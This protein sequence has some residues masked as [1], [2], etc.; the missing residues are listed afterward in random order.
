MYGLDE[1][2]NKLADYKTV[3]EI[4][5]KNGYNVPYTDESSHVKETHEKMYEKYVDAKN[6]LDG[7]YVGS[8]QEAYNQ[9]QE[10]IDAAAKVRDEYDKS[11]K[12][13][14]K[15]IDKEYWVYS[16]NGK[17]YSFANEDLRDLSRL[18]YDG[19]Y[20][21]TNMFLTS[22]D[23]QVSAINEQLKLLQSAQ[24][25]LYIASHPQYTYTTTLDNFISLYDY[26]NYTDNLNLGDYVYLGVRD[27]YAVKLRI[28][29][30]EYNPLVMDGDIT[31]EFSNMVQSK[32]SRTDWSYL[33]DQASSSGKNSSQGSSNNFL[34]NEGITLTAGLIQKLLSSGA[35]SNKV[36]QIVNNEFAG[37]IAGGSGSISINEL[38]AKMIKVT[39]IIGENG[40]FEYLQAKLISADKIVADSGDF[41]KLYAT[42]GAIDNLLAGN[43]SSEISHVIKLTADNVTIDEA[44]IRDMIAVNI[45][46]SMLKAGDISTDKFHI[47]SDDGG[48]D[49]AGNTMQFK[50]ENNVVRIQIGRDA[51]G[52]FTFCLYDETGNGI[53]IDSAGVKES[54][55]SD[56]LIKNNMIADKSIEKNKLAFN[57]VE[58]DENG[59]IDSKKVL[60]DGK[61]IDVEFTTIKNSVTTLDQK[62]DNS[63]LYNIIISTSQGSVLTPKIPET[64][65]YAHVIKL[66]QDVTDE[67]D[68]SCF[69]WKRVSTDTSGDTYWNEQHAT[70]AKSITVRKDDIL[71]GASFG[72]YFDT[73]TND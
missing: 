25:D 27:D 15:E 5:E 40:F 7:S 72:C 62:I 35:F 12:S 22:S 43:V 54:A 17:E 21:N 31:I 4:C 50:D 69:I 52:Q 14:A 59:N 71:Y 8:C 56:G 9:R 65:L 13:A 60:V 2:K 26:K 47:L 24:D 42:V 49:I 10:E 55:I 64:I 51:K 16:Q 11:R 53:L 67:F 30:I 39:D 3:I 73:H 48:I 45:T 63:V 44:V 19:D 41:K 37:I 58:A 6:Q 34:N 46:A 36:S 70:G 18:Y 57:T 1:L 29:S 38:N 28:V 33:L 66:G 68:A 23:D 61:G 20:E 32:S